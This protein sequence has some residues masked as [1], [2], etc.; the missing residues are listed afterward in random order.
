MAVH[1]MSSSW[2]HHPPPGSC[3]LQLQGASEKMLSRTAGATGL[4]ELPGPTGSGA[5]A[6][7]KREHRESGNACSA[8]TFSGHLMTDKAHCLKEAPTN[9]ITHHRLISV[10]LQQRNLWRPPF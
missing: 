1:L 9:F 6:G 5:Q 7:V 10:I 8:T 3:P 2:P 4:R